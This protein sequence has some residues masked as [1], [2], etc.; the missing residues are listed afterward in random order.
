[1][2]GFPFGRLGLKVSRS[3]MREKYGIKAGLSLPAC[4]YPVALLEITDQ[5]P[6]E[7]FQFRCRPVT[8]EANEDIPG[9]NVDGK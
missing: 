5:I 1:M 2:A 8:V 3:W 7:A 4:P 6:E 9:Q